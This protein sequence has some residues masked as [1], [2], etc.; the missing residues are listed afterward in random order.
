MGAHRQRGGGSCQDACPW[1]PSVMECVSRIS[2]AAW[3]RLPGIVRVWVQK[4]GVWTESGKTS[5]WHVRSQRWATSRRRREE[6]LV[7]ELCGAGSIRVCGSRGRGQGRR[8]EPREGAELL[9]APEKGAT[10]RT[11]R[12]ALAS[13]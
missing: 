9:Q 10:I 11:R 7:L 3:L 13:T 6:R 2:G 4:R 12:L 5:M 8:A 1:V